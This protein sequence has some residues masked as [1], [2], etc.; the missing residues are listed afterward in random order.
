MFPRTA[1]QPG[2]C[3]VNARLPENV[4]VLN[5]MFTICPKRACGAQGNGCRFAADNTENSERRRSASC[6]GKPTIFCNQNGR[7]PVFDLYYQVTVP[8]F[9]SPRLWQSNSGEGVGRI[10]EA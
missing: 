6:L 3:P 9:Y 1:A 5:P 4:L 7:R 8:S 10:S 2:C